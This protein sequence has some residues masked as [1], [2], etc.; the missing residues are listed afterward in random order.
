[1]STVWQAGTIAHIQENKKAAISGDKK[2]NQKANGE[3][4]FAV[5]FTDGTK[6]SDQLISQ[7][8]LI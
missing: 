4:V 5:P 3:S 8:A 7:F 6:P 2:Q 1:M